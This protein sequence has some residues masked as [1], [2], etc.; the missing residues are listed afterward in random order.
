MSQQFT[1][2]IPPSKLPLIKTKPEKVDKIKQLIEADANRPWYQTLRFKAYVL[3]I[4]IGLLIVGC[5]S[6]VAAFAG[7]KYYDWFQSPRAIERRRK[8][9]LKKSTSIGMI[10]SGR[11]SNA[12]S[13]LSLN[14]IGSGSR[15]PVSQESENL[16]PS[17]T[18]GLPM[19]RES[20]HKKNALDMRGGPQGYRPKSSCKAEKILQ[21]PL[22]KKKIIEVNK[23][24]SGQGKPFIEFWEDV[25]KEQAEEVRNNRVFLTLHV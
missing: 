21:D 25:K 5:C 18:Y 15:I 23:D 24:P 1:F 4:V 17:N 3:L 6:A 20:K 13:R 12:S 10:S 19:Y 11:A 2:K 7:L 8:Q 16:I 14:S 9:Q 22:F